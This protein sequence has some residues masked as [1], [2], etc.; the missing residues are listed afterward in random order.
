MNDEE[1]VLRCIQKNPGLHAAAI[2]RRTNVSAVHAVLK[3]LVESGMII[4]KE[5]RVVV[6][7]YRGKKVPRNLPTYYPNN[8]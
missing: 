5:E 4:R 6:E 8:R 3:S 7:D 1:L 2:A